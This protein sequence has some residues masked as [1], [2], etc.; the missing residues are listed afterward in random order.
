MSKYLDK[1]PHMCMFEF[2]FHFVVGEHTLYDISTSHL[3]TIV[4]WPMVCIG[5]SSTYAKNDCIS[6]W[7]M[8]CLLYLSISW[9]IMCSSL[10]YSQFL[11]L[12][13][14]SNTE[15]GVWTSSTMVFSLSISP[16]ISASLG[17]SIIRCI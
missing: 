3:S 7:V 14:L 5:K 16:F 17:R 12:L 2:K 1:F 11:C 10:L 8:R 6:H 13:F 9:L 4:V 15:K